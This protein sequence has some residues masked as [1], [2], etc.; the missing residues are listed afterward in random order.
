MPER[1]DKGSQKRLHK[2]C[3]YVNSVLRKRVWHS[4]CCNKPIVGEIGSVG[5]MLFARCGKCKEMSEIHQEE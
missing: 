5:G 2:K 3:G 4:D 1:M